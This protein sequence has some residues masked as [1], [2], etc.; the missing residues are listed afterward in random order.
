MIGPCAGQTPADFASQQRV[1]M[2]CLP[3][4]EIKK[5]FTEVETG[6]PHD[7]AVAE[8]RRCFQ[9]GVRHQITPAPCPPDVRKKR[10]RDLE[11]LKLTT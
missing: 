10:A 2:P 3:P 7:E 1:K 5:N 6:L 8:G 9:C 11:D 4:E